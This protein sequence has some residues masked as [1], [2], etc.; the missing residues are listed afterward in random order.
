M[1]DRS[2]LELLLTL[3]FGVSLRLRSS[4]LPTQATLSTARVPMLTTTRAMTT[5]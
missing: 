2:P 4:T 3:A 5:Q 1:L